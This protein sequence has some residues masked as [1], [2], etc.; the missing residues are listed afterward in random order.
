MAQVLANLLENALR[1]TPQGGSVRLSAT[2]PD[3]HWVELA[4]VDSGDGIQPADLPHIFERFYR[5]DPARRR[6]P[7]GSGSGIG[8]TISRALVEAHGGG[9]SAASAGEG[10]GSTFT[11][12][13]PAAAG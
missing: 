7:G 6:A 2:R 3:Q 9:L 11:I 4:V 10:H 5:A 1:H 12:R 8:L 13:L